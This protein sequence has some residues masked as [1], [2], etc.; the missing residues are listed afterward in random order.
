M[1]RGL[2]PAVE[3]AAAAEVKSPIIIAEILTAGAPVRAWSGVG[4]LSFGGN[5]YVGVGTF[6]GISSPEETLETKSTGLIFT[7]S[8]VPSALL[9][10]A[11]ADIRQGLAARCWLGFL[12][13]AGAVIADPTMSFEGYT[14]VPST[15]DDAETCTISISCENY[16]AT[17]GRARPTRY[18]QE[19]QETRDP[20]DKG[21]GYIPTLQDRVIPWGKA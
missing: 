6:G 8:G 15:E 7:L 9:A 5:T 13:A 16:T 10:T 11:I 19:D 21:F 17:L 12:D 4:D 3:A 18:T 1:S 14:A 2:T 20:T